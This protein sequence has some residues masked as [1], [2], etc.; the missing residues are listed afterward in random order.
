MCRNEAITLTDLLRDSEQTSRLMCITIPGCTVLDVI[1][2]GLASG[3][4]VCV[5]RADSSCVGDWRTGLVFLINPFRPGFDLK[6]L[7]NPKGFLKNLDVSGCS[8]V[9]VNDPKNYVYL[10][11]NPHLTKC[12]SFNSSLCFPQ[13]QR[14]ELKCL[15][16]INMIQDLSYNVHSVTIYIQRLS[17]TFTF[18]RK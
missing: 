12:C 11:A 13:K 2:G 7:R 16:R 14:L 8:I 15:L 17:H 6:I 3:S 10:A 1:C 18:F 4:L 5:C 9:H